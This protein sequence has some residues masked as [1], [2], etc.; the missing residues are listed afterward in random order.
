[1]LNNITALFEYKKNK[2]KLKN[3]DENQS[4]SSLA[5]KWRVFIVMIIG[6]FIFKWL[7]YIIAS[8]ITGSFL[9]IIASLILI[10]LR[11]Y[12]MF[13]NLKEIQNSKI[14][15]YVLIVETLFVGVFMLYFFGIKLPQMQY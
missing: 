1:M 10:T 9:V 3:I 15:L 5:G 6:A 7:I 8:I 11:V 2:E 4:L 14:D 13:N 12:I